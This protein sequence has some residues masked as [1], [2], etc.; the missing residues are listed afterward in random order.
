M[1]LLDY[2]GGTSG[3]SRLFS[4][5]TVQRCALSSGPANRVHSLCSPANGPWVLDSVL[6]VI[7]EV[8]DLILLLFCSAVWG[9]ATRR[10]F[11]QQGPSWSSA[12]VGKNVRLAHCFEV[13]P[14]AGLSSSLGWCG[15]RS[16]LACSLHR[17]LCGAPTQWG[18]GS[19]DSASHSLDGA[20]LAP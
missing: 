2:T 7:K 12:S 15:I 13:H 19:C 6:V 11:P 10:V 4:F 8:T 16:H 14:A 1:H 3:C 20:V 5:F 17:D 9:P 18:V